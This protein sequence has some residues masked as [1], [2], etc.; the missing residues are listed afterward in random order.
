[1]IRTGTRQ[2]SE[3]EALQRFLVA[4]GEPAPTPENVETYGESR[5]TVKPFRFGCNCGRRRAELRF[6]AC[7]FRPGT[8]WN[9]SRNRKLRRKRRSPTTDACS[10]WTAARDPIAFSMSPGGRTGNISFSI[11]PWRRTNRF[12]SSV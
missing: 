2:S 7:G 1:M 6:T 8:S 9:N 4:M 12:N 11:A 3:A 5:A 10:W